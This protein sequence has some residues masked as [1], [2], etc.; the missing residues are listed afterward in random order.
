MIIVYFN[1]S[2][3]SNKDILLKSFFYSLTANTIFLMISLLFLFGL[4]FV[5]SLIINIISFNTAFIIFYNY[6]DLKSKK[7]LMKIECN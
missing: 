1:D 4:A 6:L 2:F 7:R 3:L 5:Y